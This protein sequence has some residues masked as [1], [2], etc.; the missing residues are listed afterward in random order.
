M[1]SFQL[2]GTKYYI[3][4]ITKIQPQLLVA[5]SDFCSCYF[6]GFG[7]CAY[8]SNCP[9]PFLVPDMPLTLRHAPDLRTIKGVQHIRMHAHTLLLQ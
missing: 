3:I 5:L 8:F 4:L 6:D 2:S 1:T 9:F 7:S